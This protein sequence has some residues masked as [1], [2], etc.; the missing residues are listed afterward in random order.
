MTCTEAPVA[1]DLLPTLEHAISCVENAGES[2][3]VDSRKLAELKDRLIFG[4]FHLAVLGQFKRGKST[5]LNALIGQSILP[6]SVVPL[7]AVPTWVRAGAIPQARVEFTDTAKY[8]EL[9]TDDAAK[10]SEFLARFV[11]ESANPNNRLGVTK[12]ELYHPAPILRGGVVFIDT[13]GI[14]STFRHNTE[15]TLHFLS[16]CD[17]A[18]FLVSA[19]PPITAVEIEFLRQIRQRVVQLF[20]VLNKVDYLSCSEANEAV[21]FFRGVIVE[22]A[23][24]AEDI[25]I[26]PVSAKNALIAKSIGDPELWRS[27]GMADV[28]RHL[29]EF[30]ANEKTKSLR[31]AIRQKASDI[32]DDVV[33]RLRLSLRTLELP[34]EDLQ[35]RLETFGKRIE[36]LHLERQAA[37]DL[38]AGD[39]RRAHE[40]LEVQYEHLC[41]R[42]TLRLN[43]ALDT[44]LAATGSQMP[45]ESAL[46]ASLD[47]AIPILFDDEFRDAIQLFDQQLAEV[48]RPHQ[49]RTDKLVE[50]IRRTA[51]DLFE[52]PYRPMNHSVTFNTTREPYWVTYRYEQAFGPISPSMVDKLMS[53]HLRRRRVERRF[54]EKIEALVLY[55]AG[56]LREKLY[57]QIDRTF[58][59]FRRSLD[60]RL[61][62][63][64]AATHGAGQAAL[65][66]R[67]THAG[68]VAGEIERLGVMIGVLEQIST[69]LEQTECSLL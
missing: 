68:A 23:A 43:E 25:P 36:D 58:S 1:N 54:R 31:F 60:G 38:L 65:K 6:T 32:I 57:D 59:E 39:K 27:S 56:K 40:S 45:D 37:H 5:L 50:S 61:S 14:G 47:I 67:E 11:T 16:E 46:Q 12:V 13:P 26:F 20:F 69:R 35:S 10:L 24:I 63:A 29:V 18:L 64:I 17:A 4:R 42:G 44:E 48:L 7:T 62:A 21:T 9:A 51:A 41:K 8:E 34:L 22:Q 55:N 2:F 52:V 49:E 3:A 30:L 33:M 15:T 19:D 66:K 28:E 53:P